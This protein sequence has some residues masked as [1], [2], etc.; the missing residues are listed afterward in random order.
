MV[1]LDGEER[2]WMIRRR[3]SGDFVKVFIEVEVV[4]EHFFGG[5]WAIPQG[6]AHDVL[7]LL[8]PDVEVELL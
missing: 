7:W 1:T 2:L 4:A 6:D 8:S 3:F 5:W